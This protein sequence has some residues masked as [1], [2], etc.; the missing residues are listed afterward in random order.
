MRYGR[1]AYSWGAYTERHDV[2]SAV[3][4]TFAHFLMV[5]V[6][7]GYI[8]SLD[9]RVVEWEPR[10]ATLNAELGYKVCLSVCLSVCLPVC[11][12]VRLSVSVCLFVG[13]VGLPP[14]C[15]I[16]HWSITSLSL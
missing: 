11:L 2:A 6:E 7:R 5:A 4:P 14:R 12:S 1:I 3:K 15:A 16:I 13:W 8:G 10:L 9:D